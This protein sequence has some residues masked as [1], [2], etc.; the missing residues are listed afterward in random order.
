[1]APAVVG[2]GFVGVPLWYG[3]VGWLLL[4]DRLTASTPV[5]VSTRAAALV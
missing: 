2:S 5:P 1:V 4:R 3:W